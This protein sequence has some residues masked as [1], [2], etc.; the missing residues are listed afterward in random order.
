M[1]GREREW[2]H[3]DD[4]LRALPRGGGRTLLVDGEPGIGRSRLLGEAAAEAARRGVDVL[5]AAVPELGELVPCGILFEALDLGDLPET[6][7]TRTDSGGPTRTDSGGPTRTDSGGP[8]RAD[9]AR[10]YSGDPARAGPARAD[11]ADPAHADP[12]GP[13]GPARPGAPALER[14]KAGFLSR[15]GAP[16]LAVLDD[17]HRAD[18]ATLMTLRALQDALAPCPIGWLLSRSTLTRDGHAVALFDMLERDGA[19]RVTLGP[20]APDAVTALVT[21]TLG[22]PPDPA[23]RALAGATGGNP[24]LIT[25]LIGGLRDEGRLG[26]AGAH[27]PGRFLMVVRC[28]L[29]TLGAQAR[30]LVETAAVLDRPLLP[31]HAASLF[32]TTPAALLPVMEETVTAG[33]LAM[34]GDGLA[35][36]HEL[37][38]D[39][40]AARVPPPVRRA[41]L[42]QPGP[43]TGSR[44]AREPGPGQVAA[45]I[46]TALARGELRE[47]ERMVRERLAGR[48]DGAAGL[49]CLLAD[50]LYLTGRFGEAV[51]E[52]ET[53]L[54]V[55]RLPRGVRDRAVLVRLFA[56]TRLRDGDAA[57][58]Y[59][60]EVLDGESGYGAEVRAAA[61]IALATIEWDRGRPAAA[62]GLAD[63]AGRQARPP[64]PAEPGGP[65]YDRCLATAAMLIDAHRPDEALTML[66]R[67]RK[68]MIAQGHMAWAA[69]ASALEARAELVAGR[70]DNAVTEAERALDLAGALHTPLPAA[71]AAGVLATVALRRGDLYGAARH[72]A[73]APGGSI[74]SRTRNALLS[75]RIAEASDG[76][77]SAIAL[78]GGLPDRLRRLLVILEPTASPWLVRIAL[79]VGDR[80][81]AE[82]AVAAAES[83]SRANQGFATFDAAARHARGL[84]DTDRDALA[85]AAARTED[86]WSRASAEED[87]GVVLVAAGQREEGAAH[88]DGALA[89][90]HELGAVSDAARVRRRLRALGLRRRH[91]TNDE[92]PPSGWDSLTETERHVSMLAIDGCTNRQI[93]K[94]MFLSVHTVAF[95]LR[96]VYRKLGIS[97]RVELARLAAGAAGERHLRER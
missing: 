90:Y 55:P 19:T 44:P 12:A 92:R 3:V 61:L 21:D 27:P 9:P 53:V 60:R 63:D 80:P 1:R 24:L 93:A 13:A 38:R 96:H 37:V 20:L 11:P 32:G 45:A 85:G 51:Q 39:A 57:C 89:I 62:L 26:A 34:T 54:A 83:L 73:D 4:L 42:D 59:A 68:D 17:L 74:E 86:A 87:L 14:L 67:A 88:L 28:W 70:L 94:Q 49:R 31:E 30:S 56:A 79:A 82:A 64:G 22:E 40:I 81:A 35:F 29:D 71:T 7:P 75:A 2:H 6:G 52:S 65:R 78:L 76:P 72:L 16:A 18:P 10:A 8:A 97:S 25:E 69:D 43:L 33:I 50:V 77:R 23:T 5:R 84:L 47:A 46:D 48:G 41:L 36:R 91:W 15:A 66:R 95:H 58:S